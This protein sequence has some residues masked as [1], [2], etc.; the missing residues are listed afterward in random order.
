MTTPDPQQ[1]VD[2]AAGE[3]VDPVKF[4][5]INAEHKA[6]LKERDQLRGQI[7]EVEHTRTRATFF[8]LVI[9]AMVTILLLVFILQNMASQ[10]IHLL[11]WQ[12]NLPVGVSLLIAAIAGALITALIGGARM[13]QLNRALKKAKR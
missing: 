8:G 9:G 1:P 4:T 3:A 12:V 6:L 7:K 13:L 11:F 5:E 2:P 10:R